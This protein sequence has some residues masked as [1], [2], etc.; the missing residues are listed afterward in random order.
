MA[1][2]VVA[3]SLTPDSYTVI[4]ELGDSF[5]VV[6]PSLTPDSYTRASS[7]MSASVFRMG[8]GI[9]QL[10]FIEQRPFGRI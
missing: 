6:A 8:P 4:R 2:I 3:P 9:Q 5:K 1:L 10:A 7:T